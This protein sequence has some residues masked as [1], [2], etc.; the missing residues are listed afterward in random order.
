MDFTMLRQMACRCR[1]LAHQHNGGFQDPVLQSFSN[2]L[3]LE[4]CTVFCKLHE[5]DESEIAEY[6]LK[7]DKMSPDEYSLI[8]DY[9]N[10]MGEIFLS[11]LEL[12]DLE[13]W[14]MILPPNAKC[15]REFHEDSRTYSCASSHDANSLI[16]FHNP[17]AANIALTGVIH[18]V[19][20]IPL[21]NFAWKF[22]LVHPFQEL[23]MSHTIYH[24]YPRLMTTF[25]YAEP[26]ENLIVIEPKHIITHLTSW[27]RPAGTCPGVMKDCLVICWALN[28]GWK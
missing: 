11:W 15:L 21:N 24:Q 13:H 26:L 14:S 10:S 23:D 8:Q 16:Q 20:E 12:P 27:R 1:L 19:L 2:I 22:V 18:A 25:V 28:R 6:L 3:Q 4:D 9:L 5:L 17:N 7:A